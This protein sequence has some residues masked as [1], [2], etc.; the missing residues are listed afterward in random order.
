[1]PRTVAVLVIALAAT[2][3]AC[4][5]HRRPPDSSVDGERFGVYR[6]RFIDPGHSPRKLKIL[7]FAAPPDRL[8]AEVLPPVGGPELIIDG[9]NGRLAVTVNSRGAAWVGE[10]RVDVL[11]AILGFPV[12]LE[13]L[14]GALIHGSAM[15]GPVV[16]A[17]TPGTGPGLPRRFE[18]GLGDRVLRLELQGTRKRGRGSYAIGT[19][20]PPPGVEVR[21]IDDLVSEGG[22]FLFQE[23]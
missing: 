22:P 12:A 3:V 11:E 20:T 21:P 6:G 18:L 1:M 16:V 7:L 23:D 17:R 2:A 19:G 8:H 10:A 4:P 15:A 14:V 9:G 13:E 5:G